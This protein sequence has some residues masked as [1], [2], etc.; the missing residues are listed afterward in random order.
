MKDV[1]EM[2]RLFLDCAGAAAIITFLRYWF[3]FRLKSLRLKALYDVA[4]REHRKYLVAIHS[5]EIDKANSHLRYAS[6]LKEEI[7]RLQKLIGIE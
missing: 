3:W 6:E 2:L 4:I 7:K 1:L 5:G